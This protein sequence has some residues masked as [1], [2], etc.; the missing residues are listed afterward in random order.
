M[1]PDSYRLHDEAMMSADAAD[2]C[3]RCGDVAGRIKAL[4]A[5]IEYERAAIEAWPTLDRWL[6]VLR[7]SLES[8]VNERNTLR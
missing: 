7:H 2:Q 1:Y 8:L 6:H 5:A 4:D 3:R